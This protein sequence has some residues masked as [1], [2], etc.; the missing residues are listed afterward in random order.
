M[1]DASNNFSSRYKQHVLIETAQDY[2]LREPEGISVDL[3]EAASE[4]RSA[5]SLSGRLMQLR[6]SAMKLGRTRNREGEET[7][8]VPSAGP[9]QDLGEGPA[10]QRRPETQAPGAGVAE[11]KLESGRKEGEL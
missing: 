4:P 9:A 1:M 10:S 5:T 6:P 3:L 7:T 2:E 8:G 11:A